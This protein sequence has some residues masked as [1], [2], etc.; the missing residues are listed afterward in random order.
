MKDVERYLGLS[1]R[2]AMR[3]GEI[4]KNL[5][6]F[7]RQKKVDATE[8]DLVDMVDTIMLL[9]SHQLEIAGIECEVD[10]PAASYTAWGDSAQ[11]QQCLMNLIFNA[12]DAMPQGGKMV[13]AGGVDEKDSMIWLTISD[14]G[15]GIDADELPRIFEPFYSTKAVGK[16]VGLGLSMVYGIIREHNGIVEVNSETGKGST[17][18]IKLPR[19]LRINMRSRSA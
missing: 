11:I 1:V 5:L 13:I 16:G 6:T 8:I 2:E 9:I 14:T 4:V 18:R 15:L 19:P 7:A 3:C 17:F 10:L 12:I